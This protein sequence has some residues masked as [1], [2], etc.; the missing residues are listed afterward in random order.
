MSRAILKAAFLR[1]MYTQKRPDKLRYRATEDIRVSMKK[2]PRG[3][4]R[5][6]VVMCG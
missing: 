6:E 5:A 3:S 1:I 4:A 2:G